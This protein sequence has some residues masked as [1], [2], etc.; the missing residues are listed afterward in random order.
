M[1]DVIFFTMLAVFTAL[2][3]GTAA[4]SS[5]TTPEP[6]DPSRRTA[7]A[8]FMTYDQ[9][10]FSA[11]TSAECRV[12]RM[13][14]AGLKDDPGTIEIAGAPKFGRPLG[15]DEEKTPAIEN[16]SQSDI[17][18]K[19]RYDGITFTL[20]NP[21]H[22]STDALLVEC[23]EVTG[24]RHK[25]THGLGVGSPAGD[26]IRELGEPH[27]RSGRRL[28]YFSGP[29][30]SPNGGEK[31]ACGG[32]ASFFTDGAGRVEKIEMCPLVYNYYSA[33]GVGNSNVEAVVAETQMIRAYSDTVK[34]AG[35]KLTFKMRGGGEVA[36]ADENTGIE[37]DSSVSYQFVD[38]LA[39][40]G[41]YLV[42]IQYWEGDEYRM[43][44]ETN[45]RHF[46][47]PVK[48]EISPGKKRLAAVSASDAYNFNGI[49]VW[50]FMKGRMKREWKLEPE[51]HPA[52]H[53]I[54]WDG[55]DAF[56]VG[57]YASAEQNDMK[58]KR[59]LEVHLAK[60]GPGGWKLELEKTVD[61]PEAD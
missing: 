39:A 42:H 35:K 16:S 14:F 13:I 10:D 59:V 56:R 40:V 11:A 50:R 44:N 4:E 46:D 33:F 57:K 61:A 18:F 54:A 24:A 20:L 21:Y 7:A 9:S 26:V 3:G 58:Q 47:I 1:F 60:R 12:V 41:Y 23:V 48:P 17:R 19:L 8:A 6:A 2:F 31:V 5:A 49:E 28:T 30:K 51:G 38:R 37:S 25:L 43:V 27:A 36:F 22:N 45:G 15:T 55:D 29:F 53:F 32:H 34:R 52:F